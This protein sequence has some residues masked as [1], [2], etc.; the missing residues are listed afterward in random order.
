MRTYVHSIVLRIVSSPWD[1]LVKRNSVSFTVK[2]PS[3]YLY[4]GLPSQ[5][6]SNIM[7]I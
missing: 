7:A 3:M 5:W 4:T 6:C 2:C 1:A